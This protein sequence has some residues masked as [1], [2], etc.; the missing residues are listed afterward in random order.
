VTR[1]QR[2]TN[3]TIGVLL[4][5]SAIAVYFIIP[6][7]NVWPWV[8]MFASVGIGLSAGAAA[9]KDA[10]NKARSGAQPGA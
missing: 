3:G 5:I 6:A 4:C 2:I 10:E 1:E 9:A 7:V 8:L